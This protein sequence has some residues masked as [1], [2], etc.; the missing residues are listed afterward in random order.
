MTPRGSH[1][2]AGPSRYRD[3]GLRRPATTRSRDRSS[4]H[5]PV[6]VAR[7]PAVRAWGPEPSI[8][9]PSSFGSADRREDREPFAV[10]RNAVN[11]VSDKRMHRLS[12]DRTGRPRMIG[13]RAT[14]TPESPKPSQVGAGSG[15]RRPDARRRV[16]HRD[17]AAPPS[18][19]RHLPAAGIRQERKRQRELADRLREA[20]RSI[21][22]DLLDSDTPCGSSHCI[23]PTG[24]P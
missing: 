23:K 10:G 4:H 2:E 1:H 18:A 17:A 11:T 22:Y 9:G 13:R 20:A 19:S 5:A 6:L 14:A 7:W 21:V 24:P 3:C 8:T 15:R 12:A 16:P